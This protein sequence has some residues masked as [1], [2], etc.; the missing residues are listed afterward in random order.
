MAIGLTDLERAVLTVITEQADEAG[1]ALSVQLTS[2][3][4]ARREN[5]GSGFY[6]SLLI[7]PKSPPTKLSSPSEMFR[8][9]SWVF[10]TESAFSSGSRMSALLS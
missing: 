1:E 9:K 3:T 6:T 8:P 4:V 10:V 5:S 7:D 2:T